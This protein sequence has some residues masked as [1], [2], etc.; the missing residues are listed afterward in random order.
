MRF[1]TFLLTA[2]ALLSAAAAPLAQAQNKP[3][4]L[5]VPYAAGGPLDITARALAER[6]RY[7]SARLD[8]KFGR[9]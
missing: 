3:I 4:R 8:K 2:L 6:V 1:K 5:I 7:Y 9:R